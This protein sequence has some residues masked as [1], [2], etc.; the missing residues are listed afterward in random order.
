MTINWVILII[1][2]LVLYFAILAVLLALYFPTRHKIAEFVFYFSPDKSKYTP[3]TEQVAFL[4]KAYSEAKEAEG[5]GQV[6]V[7]RKMN[8]Y[9]PEQIKRYKRLSSILKIITFGIADLFL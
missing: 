6:S 8:P 4:E 9:I 5:K 3:T 1:N 2:I 7:S